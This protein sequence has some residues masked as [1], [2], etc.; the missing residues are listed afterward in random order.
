MGG[1]AALAGATGR[2]WAGMRIGILGGSFNPAHAGHRH[3]AL[4]A[5]R[6]LALDR[7][8][9]L[10]SPQNPLKARTGMAAIAERLAS[11][12]ALANGHPRLLVSGI[13]L[14]L[15]T[16]YT[17]DTIAALVHRCPGARFVWLMGADNLSQVHR[18]RDW[19]RIF[20][21][22]PVAVL[23][24]PDPA[25]PA[26]SSGHRA[27]RAQAAQRFSRSRFLERRATALAAL[28]RGRGRRPGW[29]FLHLRRH[30]ASSTAIRRKRTISSPS[31]AE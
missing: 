20:A 17:A 22:V 31:A 26:V 10:V 19:Q 16:T 4:E 1:L 11:A 13:E 28:R 25:H 2:R 15:G 6:R 5:L 24:R 21:A 8:V 7:V 18:W 23:D 3:I 9:M 29:V 27:L 30:P 12:R 14:L